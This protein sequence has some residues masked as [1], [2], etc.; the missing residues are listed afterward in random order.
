MDRYRKMSVNYSTDIEIVLY[1]IRVARSIRSR[2]A[3]LS[4]DSV[5]RQVFDRRVE[6]N[7]RLVE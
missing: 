5:G 6:R 1:L 3:S 4:Q 7:L 2:I